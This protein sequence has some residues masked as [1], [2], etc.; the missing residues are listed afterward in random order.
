MKEQGAGETRKR[1]ERGVSGGLRSPPPGTQA[2]PPTL[3]AWLLNLVLT[4]LVATEPAQGTAW[5]SDGFD[6]APLPGWSLAGAW[7]VSD[8]GSDPCYDS[9]NANHPSAANSPPNA[10]SYHYDTAPPAT[11]GNDCTYD[12]DG[13]GTSAANSG[14]LTSPQFDLSSS[15][16]IVW[17]HFSTWRETEG[18]PNFDQIVVYT[19]SGAVAFP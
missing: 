2:R 8:T 12:L 1:P 16:P 15:G 10:M 5:F 18:D 4:A 14:S 9:V 11:A 3:C 19:P 17:L 6:P 7:H 13:G